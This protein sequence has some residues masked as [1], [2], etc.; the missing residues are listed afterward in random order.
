[1]LKRFLKNSM[2]GLK[3]FEGSNVESLYQTET[4]T[5]KR[6][7]L[8]MLEAFVMRVWQRIKQAGMVTKAL[9]KAVINDGS[10]CS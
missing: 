10:W 1:M 4:W 9:L 8:M 6:M 3:N 5:V 7:K 2:N